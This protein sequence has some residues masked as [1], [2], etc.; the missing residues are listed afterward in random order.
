MVILTV[1]YSDEEDEDE[2]ALLYLPVAPDIEE[3][4]EGW[5]AVPIVEHVWSLL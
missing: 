5:G 3:P 2:D 1:C 4:E